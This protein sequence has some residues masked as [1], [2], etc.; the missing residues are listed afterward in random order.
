MGGITSPPI[1]C[2]ERRRWSLNS[3]SRRQ[4][5]TSA[6]PLLL[7]CQKKKNRTG[8]KPAL[9][10]DPFGQAL[11]LS[12]GQPAPAHD[13]AFA[14]SKRLASFLGASRRDAGA[15][16][17]GR[18][19]AGGQRLLSI[20]RSHGVHTERLLDF[21]GMSWKAAPRKSPEKNSSA[22]SICSKSLPPIL[23]F[24]TVKKIR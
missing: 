7:R 23:P 8:K 5:E 1:S 6:A 2:P 13:S 18:L 21:T 15:C 4:G 12:E 3:P 11:E 24:S 20:H 10:S 17:R 19:L 14:T 16:P 9:C 22:I